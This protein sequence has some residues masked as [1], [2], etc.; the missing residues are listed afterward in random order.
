M[1]VVELEESSLVHILLAS[2]PSLSDS[3]ELLHPRT[4]LYTLFSL[5]PQPV[6]HHNHTLP[7]SHPP[8]PSFLHSSVSGAHWTA[9]FLY[10]FGL[11]LLVHSAQTKSKK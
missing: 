10:L 2:L 11:R 5:S 4:L 7:L 9:T 6:L 1:S 8:F 3:L